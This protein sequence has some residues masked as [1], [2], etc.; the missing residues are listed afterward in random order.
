MKIGFRD[1]TNQ[2]FG[3]LVVIKRAPN[4]GKKVAWYCQ[5]DCGKTT[6][7]TTTNLCQ[8][9]MFS[10]GCLKMEKLLQRSTK[11][12]LSRTKIY[13]VW[14]AIRKR[15]YSPANISYK[16]YGGRGITICEDW[17]NNFS[18]FY[19]WSMKNGYKEGLSIDR[20]D[21]NGNY[22]PENCRWTDKLTQANNTRTNHFITFCNQTKTIAE[23]ARHFN[24]PYSNIL[25]KLQKN[26]YDAEKA[27]AKLVDI[28]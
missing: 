20:I 25:A 4:K 1:L 26:N 18:S 6:I 19:E 9:L 3:R 10:C 7:A 16:N 5:C 27:F 11:H 12:N 28:N 21:N 22:C 2:R 15:C 8:H 17:K 13:D 14:I 24:L 23:W